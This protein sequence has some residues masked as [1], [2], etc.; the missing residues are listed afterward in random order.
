[1]GVVTIVRRV[2]LGFGILLLG[3]A[4]SAAAQDDIADKIINNPSPTSYNVYGLP[5]PPK[6]RKDPT[7][8]GEKALRIVIPGAGANPYTIGLQDPILK[9]VKA[10]DKLVLAFWARFEKAEGTTVNLANAS[11]QLA[12]EPYTG[13]FGKSFEIGP[14]WKMYNVEGKADRDYA[15]GEIN[16][17]MH[18]ATGK[19]TIDIGP[20]FL[21]DMGQ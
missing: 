9:P 7:V 4:S 6:V 20:I 15:A 18:L 21:L 19:Q 14:E 13:L 2:A 10:G 1:M 5:N 11:V 12:K 17:S 8:Q 16:V 3:V